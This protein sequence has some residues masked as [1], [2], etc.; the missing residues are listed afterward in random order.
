MASARCQRGGGGRRIGAGSQRVSGLPQPD[1]HTSMRSLLFAAAILVPA[2]VVPGSARPQT[3]DGTLDRALAAYAR[4]R[5]VHAQF[6]QTVTNPLVGTKADSRGEVIQQRP[7]YLLVR[8]TTPSG[9]RIV[10]DG[11]WVW[12]YL[13]SS[14]PGQVIRAPIGGDGSGVP[15]V[16]AQFLSA[17]RGRYTVA[18]GGPASVGGRGAHVLRLAARDRSLPFEKATVWV[19][20]R[21]GL[22]RQFETVDASGVVRRVTMSDMVVNAPVDRAVFVF[23]PPRGVRV[24]TQPS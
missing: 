4:V 2:T 9:D 12:I 19:D 5:T 24:F 11:M 18:D 3:G 8:F 22:V 16:T 10:A 17:P 7:Q 23:I 20:D 6:M 21:D 14:N 15:D 1:D 13:P